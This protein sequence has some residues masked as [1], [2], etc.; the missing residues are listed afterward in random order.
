VSLWPTAGVYSMDPAEYFADPVPADQGGSLSC[1]GA[2]RLLP[3]NCPALFD[4]ERR[5][6]GRPNKDAFDFG[7]AAHEFVL[8]IGAGIIPVDAPDWRTKAAREAKAAAYAA[9][10][11][12]LLLD[13]MEVVKAMAE[14]IRAHPIAAALLNPENGKPEQA[15]FRQDEKEGVWLRSMLDWLPD[16]GDGRMIVPDYKTTTSA[17]PERFRKSFADFGYHQQA[18]FYT[19][20]VLALDLAEEAAFVF[21]AQ[22]KSPPYLVSVFEP[23]AVALRIGRELNREAI[24]LYAACQSSGVWPGYS[25][26]VELISLPEWAVYSHN[27]RSIQ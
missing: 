6:G 15:L 8:G 26:E 21:I 23:D 1:S 2:K 17:A 12:P 24:D 4:Y 22:E 3:P 25:S 10:L 7:H 14:A 27:L 13:D 9:G 20:M 5:N 11:V 18:A 16:A 19:D